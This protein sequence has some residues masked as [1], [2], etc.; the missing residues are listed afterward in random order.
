MAF[1][2][3]TSPR[4]DKHIDRS[5]WNK[6]WEDD[7]KRYELL[8]HDVFANVGISTERR[9]FNDA[10]TPQSRLWLEKQTQHICVLQQDIRNY[11]LPRLATDDL[12]AK[13]N[14][15][16]L[17]RRK[18]ILLEALYQT[19]CVAHDMENYR[20]WCPEMTLPNLSANNGRLFIDLLKE[21]LPDDPT[22][23]PIIF[24]HPT[25]DLISR[26]KSLEPLKP[27]IESNRC[28]F[29]S[30]TVW[31]ILLALYDV[32]ESYNLAKLSN[33]RTSRKEGLAFTKQIFG[34]EA[35]SIIR[36]ELKA[37]KK[38]AELAVPVCWHCDKDQ[39]Q[40]PAGLQLK[41]CSKCK[42][43]GRLIHYCSKECQRENW[44]KGIP[45]PH[46]L[47]CGRPLMEEN[48]QTSQKGRD[49]DDKI[50]EPDPSFKRTP[51]LLHQIKLLKTE[52]NP[53]YVLVQPG[54][55][56]PDIGIQIPDP[57]I[58]NIF[59]IFRRRAL[60]SGDSIAV[61]LMC[62]ILLSFIVHSQFTAKKLVDQLEKEYGVK[63]NQEKDMGLD[64][65]KLP[66]EEEEEW[67]KNLVQ[68]FENMQINLKN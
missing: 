34:K 11:A 53:D 33:T 30:M 10:L 52:A 18:E 55:V 32:D 44:K 3:L 40:L 38:L 65:L 9:K 14:K 47:I 39:S 59:L 58:R 16:D 66:T 5:A 42:E 51:A 68:S 8:P 17:D 45:R 28:Y 4:P 54:L 60:K 25:I 20:K 43:I 57:G 31:R 67:A 46:K 56:D 19:S 49:F 24:M 36:Q 2:N 26:Y 35:K 41:V 48:Q 15:L 1:L 13:W 63:V 23:Q 7:L 12:E 64:N 50:P 37:H 29:I 61:N 62:Q 22:K 6:S 27:A 21:I